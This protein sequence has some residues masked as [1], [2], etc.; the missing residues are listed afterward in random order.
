MPK[1]RIQTNPKR[2]RPTYLVV[3]PPT[4]VQPQAVYDY[5]LGFSSPKFV[6]PYDHVDPQMSQEADSKLEKLL[7]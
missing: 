6:T 7:R 5:R 4:A 1:R 3:V 2:P